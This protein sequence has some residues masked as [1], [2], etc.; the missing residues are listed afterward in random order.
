MHLTRL[1]AH[2]PRYCHVREG[3]YRRCRD[4]SFAE[5]RDTLSLSEKE[6]GCSWM[7][8]ISTARLNANSFI[9]C[10]TQSLGFRFLAPRKSYRR[11]NVLSPQNVDLFFYAV[12]LY[13]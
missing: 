4:G 2:I 9:E 8:T 5:W 7:R 6:S 13:T 3:F 12:H 1:Q 11:S 10:I